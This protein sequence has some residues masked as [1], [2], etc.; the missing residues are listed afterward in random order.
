MVKTKQNSTD[1]N[2]LAL[3]SNNIFRSLPG[4]TTAI[5]SEWYIY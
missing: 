4:Y 2:I 1:R 3:L 5:K